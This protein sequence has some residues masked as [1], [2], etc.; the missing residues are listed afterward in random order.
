MDDEVGLR[1][2]L[3]MNRPPMPFDWAQTRLGVESW[4]ELTHEQLVT[5]EAEWSYAYAD[6][7]LKV[8]SE[9]V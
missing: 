4:A 2:L 1:D 8:R 9:G 7:C 5:A 6:A 3:A